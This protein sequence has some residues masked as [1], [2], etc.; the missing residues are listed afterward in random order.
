MTRQESGS[1]TVFLSLTLMLLISFLCTGLRSAQAAGSRYLLAV[2]AEATVQSVFGAYDTK[3]WEQYRV[4][5]LTDQDLA[6]EIAKECAKTYEESG[7]LFSLSDVTAQLTESVTLAENGAAGWQEAMVSYMEV[8]LPVDLVSRWMEQLDLWEGL[9]NIGQWMTGLSSLVKPLLKLEQTLCQLE[10]DVKDVVET[11][12]KGKDLLQE[13]KI[14]CEAVKTLWSMAE[15]GAPVSEEE[16]DTAWS[17]LE[18]SY[19]KVEDYLEDSGW[20][21]NSMV[22]KARESLEAAVQLET[23]VTERMQSLSGDGGGLAALADLGG[24]LSGLTQR[25]GFLQR[26]PGELEE[27]NQ[28]FDQIAQV[29]LPSLEEVRAGV[30]REIPDLL[31]GMAEGFVSQVWQPELPESELTGPE[32]G[33]QEEEQVGL[34]M[35]LRSWLDQGVLALVLQD[36]DQVSVASLGRGLERSQRQEEESFWQQ[37]YDRVLCAEYALRY[38]ANGSGGVAVQAAYG[39]DGMQRT[40]PPS[41][42]AGLQYETE[43]VIAGHT[44]DRSNLSAVAQ[45][46]LWMRGALNLT[47]LL[48][49]EMSR[50]SLRLT[51][52]GFSAALGGWIPVG[53]MTVL[54]MVVWAMAEAVCDVRAL[55]TGRQVP[56]WKDED[57]WKLA[58]EHLWTLLEDGFVTGMD[59]KDGMNYQEYLRILLY[60]VPTQEM[61]YR[62][63]EVAEENLRASRPTFCIDQGWCQATV[64][65]NGQAAGQAVERQ[66]TYGY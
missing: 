6:G 48:Q 62:I 4:L 16:W 32:Q 43:Y 10:K 41:A 60:L 66:M 31:L 54:L 14:C 37:A 57:S 1:I 11:Y 56:F 28:Y 13:L 23:M 7:T 50:E 61:C 45:R 36:A 44:Q 35:Q 55:L 63:M 25:L 49:D 52:A 30:G 3:V 46:L 47:Y 64:V 26:L 9:E 38:T 51:A 5:M 27:Q 24:Y 18:D 19:G 65:L 22:K 17:A 8:R 34:L 58:W 33:T 29:S 12:Q 15:S 40:I 2:A 59:R 21:R 42:G 39:D 20:Q 53:L